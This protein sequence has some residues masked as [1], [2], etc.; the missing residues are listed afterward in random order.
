MG[1]RWL[2]PS[3]LEMTV[4][5]VE[6]AESRI[7]DRSGKVD[8]SVTGVLALSYKYAPITGTKSVTSYC[9]DF[10]KVRFVVTGIKRGEYSVT[11]NGSAPTAVKP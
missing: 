2:S 10:V 11:I 6:T 3:K 5:D 7:L 9:S 4:W 1:S 8:R